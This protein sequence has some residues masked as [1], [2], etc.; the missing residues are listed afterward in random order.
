MR[1]W[2]QTCL[3]VGILCTS[4]LTW[5]AYAAVR[6]SEATTPD[7]TSI[8]RPWARASLDFFPPSSGL[9]PVT[10]DKAH[11]QFD[12]GVNGEGIVRRA[13][14]HWETSQIRT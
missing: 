10:Y 12:T 5:Q 9:G 2:T 4:I 11:P 1:K 7:F 3:A 6:E 8:D 13:P 14:L